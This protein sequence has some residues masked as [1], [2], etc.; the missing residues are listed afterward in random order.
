LDR[1]LEDVIK[2]FQNQLVNQLP[3]INTA[4]EQKKL[5]PI[6]GMSESDWQKQRQEAPQAKASGMEM[7]ERD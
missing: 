6:Q 1:E 2:K 5:E 4:L 3:A 7:R